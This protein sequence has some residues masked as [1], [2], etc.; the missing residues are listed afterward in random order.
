MDLR[1]AMEVR[2]HIMKGKS[3]PSQL[4]IISATNDF[5]HCGSQEDCLPNSISGACVTVKFW[6]LRAQI[7]PCMSL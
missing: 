1:F 4:I 2:G 7:A 6:Y 3:R 5:L